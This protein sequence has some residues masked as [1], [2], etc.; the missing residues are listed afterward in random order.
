MA[1]NLSPPYV[2]YFPYL[3]VYSPYSLALLTL[4]YY[5]S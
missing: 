5:D 1:Q 2:Y 4:A 3:Y